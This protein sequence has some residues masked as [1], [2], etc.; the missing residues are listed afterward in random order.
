M[1]YK[2]DLIYLHRN[3][4]DQIQ[5][6]NLFEILIKIFIEGKIEII[7]NSKTIM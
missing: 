1:K 3:L 2:K 5:I 6:N 7:M 4:Y